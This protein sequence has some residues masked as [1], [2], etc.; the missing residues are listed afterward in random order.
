MNSRI[1]NLMRI[2]K[3]DARVVGCQADIDSD[4]IFDV[5]FSVFNK[6]CIENR[7]YSLKWLN[8][9]LHR[10]NDEYNAM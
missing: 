6:N 9:A 2:A 1:R 7:E 10:E 3:L 8:N 5:D 4:H